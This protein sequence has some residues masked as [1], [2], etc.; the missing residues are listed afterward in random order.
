MTG[1]FHCRKCQTEGNGVLNYW[2]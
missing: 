1:I 2:I